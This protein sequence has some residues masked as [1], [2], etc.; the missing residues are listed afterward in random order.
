MHIVQ[1]CHRTHGGR[2]KLHDQVCLVATKALSQLRWAV[3]MEPRFQI[4][5]ATMLKPDN[6]GSKNESIN[7][8]YALVVY[9]GQPLDQ[10]LKV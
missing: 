5:P 8:I 2:I 6:I 9:A 10:S 3:L 1:G 7:V 4:S